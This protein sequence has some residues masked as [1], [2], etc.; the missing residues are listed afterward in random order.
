MKDGSPTKIDANNTLGQ[1]HPRGLRLF[2]SRVPDDA[3]GGWTYD[4]ALNFIFL[5]FLLFTSWCVF[6]SHSHSL[7][8]IAALG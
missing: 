4:D 8:R 6:V 1:S 2:F 5:G 7:P 3:W